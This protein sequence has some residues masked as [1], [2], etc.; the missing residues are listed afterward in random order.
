VIADRAAKEPSADIRLLA[1][2]LRQMFVAL[3]AEGFS[4]RQALVIIGQALI[5]QTKGETT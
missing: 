2:V 3:V 4:E 5:A 1:S